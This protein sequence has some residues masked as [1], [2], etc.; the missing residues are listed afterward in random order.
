MGLARAEFSVTEPFYDR[1]AYERGENLRDI[2]PKECPDGSDFGLLDFKPYW[3]TKETEVASCLYYDHEDDFFTIEHVWIEGKKAMEYS[4]IDGIPAGPQ[5][6]KSEGLPFYYI[7]EMCDGLPIRT[8]VVGENS[9]VLLV[10]LYLSN[11]EEPDVVL[12][13]SDPSKNEGE[14]LIPSFEPCDYSLHNIRN[15]LFNE[16]LNR[17]WFPLPKK[18]NK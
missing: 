7:T 14:S 17:T 5:I 8:E 12:N 15:E 6:I 9:E 2:K 18:S 4:E 10:F 16:W 3:A 11:T 1:E 13:V